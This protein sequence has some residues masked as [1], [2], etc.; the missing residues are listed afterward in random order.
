MHDVSE[1]TGYLQN[2][3][4][5]YFMIDID[6]FPMSLLFSRFFPVDGF[7]SYTFVAPFNYHQLSAP[8]S[9]PI[10]FIGKIAKFRNRHRRCLLNNHNPCERQDHFAVPS[11]RTE[12]RIE[13]SYPEDNA[14][15]PIT[16]KR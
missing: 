6:H 9:Q 4:K 16:G 12:Q 14:Y 1:N 13:T 7:S 8:Y 10:K 11:H 5:K 15:P 2:P 3:C